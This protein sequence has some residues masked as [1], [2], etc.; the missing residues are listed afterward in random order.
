M[1][2]IYGHI[3]FNTRVQNGRNKRNMP[4]YQFVQHGENNES[5]ILIGSKNNH[6]YTDQYAIINNK[7]NSLNELIGPVNSYDATKKFILKSNDIKQN[8]E[9]YE[10]NFRDYYDEYF[11]D[12]IFTIDDE[13]TTDY[14]DA[15]SYDPISNSLYIFITDLTSINVKNIDNLVNIGYSFYDSE[16]TYH[17]FN[18]DIKNSFSLIAGEKR[19]TFCLKVN[20]TTKNIE[21]KKKSIIVTE[22]LTYDKVDKLLIDDEKWKSFKTNFDSFFGPTNNSHEIIEKMMIYYNSMFHLNLPD[23]KYPV[24][25]HPG[26]KLSKDNVELLNSVDQNLAKKLCY[27]SAEYCLNSNSNSYHYGLS[28]YNYM[29]VT[30][31][32]RRVIDFITQKI[33]FTKE[34]FDLKEICKKCNDRLIQNK[35]AYNEIKLLN[36]LFKL[37][38]SEEREFSALILNFDQTKVNIY[39]PDLDIIHN[40]SL[41]SKKF[42]NLVKVELKDNIIT[43]YHVRDNKN[44]ISFSKF[45]LIKVKAMVKTSE[46]YLHKKIKFYVVDDNISQIFN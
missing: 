10:F 31:P 22:N 28:I 34:V 11:S 44:L 9:T 37:K 2:Q 36:L 1:S 14:D 5:K 41:I 26:F 13:T 38:E 25:A 43:I 45:Q 21:F 30:S 27:H 20:F 23:K 29:H 16:F 3:K 33:A 32:L 40:I 18:E 8:K 6:K 42:E 46:L 7:D 35:K 19:N 15:F 4:L 17:L 12:F 24:R 39:I